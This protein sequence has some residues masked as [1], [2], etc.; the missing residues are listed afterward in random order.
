MCLE[1]KKNMVYKNLQYF[2]PVVKAFLGFI[3]QL[4]T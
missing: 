3:D 1:N 4:C 2:L